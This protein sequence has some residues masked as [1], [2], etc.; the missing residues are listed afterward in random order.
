MDHISS[1]GMERGS[2][3]M[4][5]LYVLKVSERKRPASILARKSHRAILKHLE[6]AFTSFLLI[7][8]A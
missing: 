1:W 7:S 8:L 2:I 3:L 4:A 6:R 5:S